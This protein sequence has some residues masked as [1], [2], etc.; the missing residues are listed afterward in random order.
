MREITISLGASTNQPIYSQDGVRY[1]QRPPDHKIG[2]P[3]SRDDWGS[4]EPL[5]LQFKVKDTGRGM[6]EDEM[7]VLFQRFSQASHRTHTEYG[8]SG[9]GLFIARLLTQLQGGDIG[10]ASAPQKGSTFAFYIKVRRAT[11]SA[12]SVVVSADTILGDSRDGIQPVTPRDC[13]ELAVFVVEDNL[14]NQKV[15]GR[16]LRQVGFTVCR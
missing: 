13:S 1:L 5:F 7:K 11:P 8:G 4:G 10:V 16:Q 12:D 2:D 9:L 6:S 3:I 15:L 14:V